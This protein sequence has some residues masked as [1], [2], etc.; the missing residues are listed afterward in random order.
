MGEGLVF[1]AHRWLYHSTLGSRVIKKKKKWAKLTVQLQKLQLGR[2]LFLWG[3]FSAHRA[4]GESRG[5]LF[6]GSSFGFRVSA[7]RLWVVGFG[8]WVCSFNRAQFAGVF[9]VEEVALLE[10][11]EKYVWKPSSYLRLIDSCITQ[12]KAR[13]PSRTCNES[14]EEEEG[15]LLPASSLGTDC[16]ANLEPR[17]QNSSSSSLLSLQVLEGP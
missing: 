5:I 3:N 8:V 17:T 12:L 1:K 9:R 10:I 7:F 13:G 11:R 14:K 2:F 15:K 4:T 16:P 6:R